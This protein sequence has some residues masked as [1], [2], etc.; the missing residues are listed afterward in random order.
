M[1]NEAGTSETPRDYGFLKPLAAGIERPRPGFFYSLGLLLVSLTMVLLPVV[2]VALI[3][4]AGW[5]VYYHAFHHFEPIMSWGSK[6][7]RVMLIKLLV[8]ATPIVVG[9]ITVFFM[10]KPL[11]SRRPKPPQSLA[12]NPANEPVLFAFIAAV[13]QA[14]GAPM[15][16][17]VDLDCQLNA[18]AGFRRGFLSFLGSDL[19]LVIGLPL[20]GNLSVAEF[21][22]VL[23]HEFGHFAQGLG[24]RLS[25]LV[26]SVNRWFARVVFERDAWDLWL[27]ET[28]EQADAWW[29]LI[30]FNVARLGVWFSR[31]ILHGLM[32][33]GHGISCFM[34]RQMEYDADLHEIRL[35]GSE[36]FERT[37]QKLATLGIALDRCYQSM[38]AGW[39]ASHR[40]PESVPAA[41]QLTHDQLPAPLIERTR[42]ELGLKRSGTFATHPSPAERIRQARRENAS[43]IFSDDR[44]ASVLFENFAI[45]ARQVTLLHYREDLGLLVAPEMIMPVTGPARAAESDPPRPALLEEFSFIESLVLPLRHETDVE[46]EDPVVARQAVEEIDA[47]LAA[48][49]PTLEGI[50][51]E[52][53]ENQ[54]AWIAAEARRRLAEAGILLNTGEA[55]PAEQWREAIDAQRH[56]LHEVATALDRRLALSR[57]IGGGPVNEHQAEQTELRTLAAA[58]GEWREIAHELAVV[59]EIKRLLPGTSPDQATDILGRQLQ[60]VEERAREIRNRGSGGSAT[61]RKRIQFKTSTASNTEMLNRLWAEAQAS[62]DAYRQRLAGIWNTARQQQ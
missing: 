27:E 7:W 11:L 15:P 38:R 22:G 50:A 56:S 37:M 55:V 21:A 14:V 10:I 1:E 44:P 29:E 52:H 62:L 23:A 34:S 47:Q 48:L 6:N 32:L 53:A 33:L 9:L 30:L 17:R 43:G 46:T 57:I 25:Y 60:Q 59:R 36:V 24:M 42:G 40:L 8:Y 54:A 5:A 49:K 20:A 13:C 61:A 18:A 58:Y 2:Y 26:G 28:A 41:L 45:P 51:S 31:L 3:L 4:L 16:R 19:V 12:L 39:N 35:S